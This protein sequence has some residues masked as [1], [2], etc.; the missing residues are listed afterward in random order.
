MTRIAL[1]KHLGKKVKITLFDGDVI[2]GTLHKSG[3]ECF[4]NIANLYIPNNLYF[5]TDGSR[6]CSCLFKVS[7][8]KR[9]GIE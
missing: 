5:L 7:H 6:L 8:I 9:I 3:E 2:T 4:K 1:E